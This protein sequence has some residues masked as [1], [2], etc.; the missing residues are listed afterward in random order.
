MKTRIC[1]KIIQGVD[2]EQ[3]KQDLPLVVVA[4]WEHGAPSYYTNS[5]IFKI[6]FLM[7]RSSAKPFV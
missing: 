2:E 1:F 7:P 6:R 3:M 5:Y 4:Y